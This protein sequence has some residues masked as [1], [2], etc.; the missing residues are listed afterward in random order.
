MDFFARQ[1]QARR[2]TRRLI[3]LFILAVISIVLTVNAL[4]AASYIYIVNMD[5]QGNYAGSL[6]QQFAKVPNELFI[7][8]SLFVVI[9]IAAGS[10]FRIAQLSKGGVAVAKLVGAKRVN[11]NTRDHDE[12]RLLNVVDEMAIASGTAVPG[13]YVMEEED[14]INAFAAG[15][16]PNRAV[17][18]VTRGTL[19]QLDRDQ[20]QGVVAH[21]FSH[22]LNGDMRMNIRLMGIL[23]G[24]LLI[25]IIGRMILRSTT[26]GSSRNKKGGAIVIAALGLLVIGYLGVFFGRLIQAS[27]S[28]QREFLA[29]S[30]AVQFTRN[31]DG[32]AG[33]LRKIRSSTSLMEN[34]Y[35]E[36]MS[37]MFFGQGVKAAIT[38]MF[39][40]HPPLK[41]RI[42]RIN[43][44][45]LAREKAPPG[46][47]SSTVKKEQTEKPR[48]GIGAEDIAR[49][50]VITAVMAEATTVKAV[51]GDVYDSL[52]NPLP[53]H[54]AYAAALLEELPDE[55]REA[56]QHEEGACTAV[57]ALLLHQDGAYKQR[58]LDAISAAYSQAVTEQVLS[59]NN[60]TVKLG[61]SFNLPIIDMALAALEQMEQSHRM[62]FINTLRDV[63]EA[64]R[65]ISLNEFVVF[66]LVDEQLGE[67]SGKPYRYR[68]NSLAALSSEITLVLSIIAISGHR[69]LIEAEK[70]FTKAIKSIGQNNTKLLSHDRINMKNIS[71][72]LKKIKLLNPQVKAK[73]VH[74]MIESV[75]ADNEVKISET[76]LMRAICAGIDVPVPPLLTNESN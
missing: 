36:E 15:Y 2:S 46:K 71:Q 61:R 51:P 69:E 3:I 40:T 75:L 47:T 24:I 59:L 30:S 16:S 48:T 68:Y 54:V 25:A 27:V 38:G 63:I 1:D 50:A 60:V 17:V 22:I 32:I 57:F 74:A 6:S 53:E 11:R 43:K 20:L 37:H 62:K 8:T 10:V 52:G 33:A 13:V 35:A 18:A 66:S 29:D 14:G 76:E 49:V 55:L 19:E 72:A 42:K 5:Q 31:P 70:S 12:R 9:L 39:A 41:E 45:F 21:E 34:E 28:R 23:N 73:L 67:E 44:A 65:K 4:I 7:W 26:R 64:D 56:L 58:Q